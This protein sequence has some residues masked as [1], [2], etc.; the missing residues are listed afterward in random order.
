MLELISVSEDII[1]DLQGAIHNIDCRELLKNL[2]D[3][4]VQMIFADPPFNLDLQYT[5]Y[6]DKISEKEYFDWTESWISKCKRVLKPDGTIFVYNIPKN[7]VKTAPIL[8]KYFVFQHWIAW[9]SSGRPAKLKLY[10]A[11]YGILFY[12]KNNDSKFYSVRYPHETCFKCGGF[13]RDYGGKQDKRHKFGPV[14]S[15][16]WNDIHRSRHKE[17][18]ISDHPC[19]LP[20][21]FVERLILMTTDEHDL[22]LDLFAG[23][24]SAGIAAKHLGR[25]Y[26]GA[27]IDNHY[28]V[29]SNRRIEKIGKTKDINDNYISL[30]DRKPVSIREVV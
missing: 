15:D 26:I 29:Q 2:P 28:V 23:G 19:Q 3:E 17:G 4:S 5:K 14:V 1:D 12:T 18:K 27:E 6:K 21:H 25:N 8:E 16:V 24:G 7:L 10:P 9:N 20:P 22:V 13:S 30:F 11:H